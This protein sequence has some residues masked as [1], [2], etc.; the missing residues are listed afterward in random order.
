MAEA[1]PPEGVP[2]SEE[3]TAQ[4]T[5]PTDPAAPA[6]EAAAE[7]EPAPEPTSEAEAAAE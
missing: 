1:A 7:P 4:E 2:P 6:A 3:T 5:M